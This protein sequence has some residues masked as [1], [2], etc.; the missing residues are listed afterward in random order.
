MFFFIIINLSNYETFLDT[1]FFLSMIGH[2]QLF[3]ITRIKQANKYKIQKKKA[4]IRQKNKPSQYFTIFVI[5]YN[6][7][8]ANGYIK[9]ITF[10]LC[11]S[12]LL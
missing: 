11:S 9:Y 6:P 5:K 4:N 8:Y 7:D 3:Q 1:L 2:I 10:N 12:T